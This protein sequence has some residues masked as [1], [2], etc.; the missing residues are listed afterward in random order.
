MILTMKNLNNNI[1]KNTHNKSFK[2]V[3]LMLNLNK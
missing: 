3:Y 1:Y 2:M